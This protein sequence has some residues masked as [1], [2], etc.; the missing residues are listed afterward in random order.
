[1]LASAS[2][3]SPLLRQRDRR[4][5]FLSPSDS[6]SILQNEARNKISEYTNYYT[7]HLNKTFLKINSFICPC[8]AKL[9]MSA[10]YQIRNVRFLF[11]FISPAPYMIL[12]RN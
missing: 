12:R 1:M 2:G 3:V 7:Y 8:P 10:F 9:E 11:N 4:N 6:L 5:T